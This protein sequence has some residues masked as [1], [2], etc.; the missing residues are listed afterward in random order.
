SS[1]AQKEE[2]Q[3]GNN[4][5]SYSD[6]PPASMTTTIVS[7]PQGQ[8]RGTSE[9]A[10]PKTEDDVPPAGRS[11]EVGAG[12]LM[13]MSDPMSLSLSGQ[14]ARVEEKRTEV[15]G[16][17]VGS[18]VDP[19]SRSSSVYVDV[20]G[21]SPSVPLRVVTK[22]TSY[23]PPTLPYPAN[24][25]TDNSTLPAS[26]PY[27]QQPF[28]HQT[29][30]REDASHVQAL[31]ADHLQ[32]ELGQGQRQ[33]HHRH[34]YE[35]QPHLPCRQP[36]VPLVDM[37]GSQGTRRGSWGSDG[38]HHLRQQETAHLLRPHV[39]GRAPVLRPG[40]EAQAGGGPWLM[41]GGGDNSSPVQEAND[42]TS[43]S[44]ASRQLRCTSGENGDL[45]GF[46]MGQQLH[47]E[48]GSPAR[49]M[50]G[51]RAA[52]LLPLQITNPPSPARQAQECLQQQHQQHY[53]HVHQQHI[54]RLPHYL[55][56]S[57]A[58]M[59][60]TGIGAAEGR[61]WP[62]AGTQERF[63]SGHSNATHASRSSGAGA[64]HLLD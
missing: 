18:G 47:S 41:A 64:G 56:I 49:Q 45:P 12:D 13:S 61:G 31:A 19:E 32:L 44:T 55:S 35:N 48:Q 62:G 3:R 36:T 58:E 17:E 39:Q 57:G 14:G 15:A 33:G 59:R 46:S 2:E 7:G 50:M 26:L 21:G 40:G 53:Q 52:T 38:G 42:R 20:S 25:S 60:G 10:Q 37:S 8:G 24:I 11:M 43:S 16:D 9:G 27:E 5:G 34:L 4:R 30:A 54:Q 6:A 1:G 63:L 23:T 28:Q 22:S 29:T 51:Q